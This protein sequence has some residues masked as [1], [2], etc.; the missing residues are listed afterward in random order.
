MPVLS[1]P[2][3]DR[4]A[5]PPAGSAGGKRAFLWETLPA[6]PAPPSGTDP[7]AAFRVPPGY[8][9]VNLPTPSLFAYKTGSQQMN[10]PAVITYRCAKCRPT[11]NACAHFHRAHIRHPP[12]SAL[13]PPSPPAGRNRADAGGTSPA[14]GRPPAWRD[15]AARNRK[16]RPTG[17]PLHR[18]ANAV[19]TGNSAHLRYPAPRPASDEQ[20][21]PVP[22]CPTARR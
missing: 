19:C 4:L 18:R 16:D 17:F 14:T 15:N 20:Y 22:P 11:V 13:R 10:A 9:A 6:P 2:P 5:P 3:A 7:T 8:S 1:A 12:Y 21:R